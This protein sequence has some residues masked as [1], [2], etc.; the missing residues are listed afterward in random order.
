MLRP[1]ALHLALRLGWHYQAVRTRHALGFALINALYWACYTSLARLAGAW[2]MVG[3]MAGVQGLN[4][5]K[6]CTERATPAWRGSLV[7]GLW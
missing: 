6:C 3:S 1:Q 4:P 2:L 7:R 5:L